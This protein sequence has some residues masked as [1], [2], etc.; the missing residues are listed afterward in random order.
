MVLS[1]HR[2]KISMAVVCLD[3][4]ILIWAMQKCASGER[5]NCIIIAESLIDDLTKNNDRIIIPSIV[6]AEL[7]A[8]I[9]D[10]RSKEF[11]DLI[12]SRFYIVPFDALAAYYYAVIFRRN[13]VANKN[14]LQQINPGRVNRS[15]DI[16]VLATAIAHKASV[17]YSED[18]HIH[19]LSA[20]SSEFVSV[21]RMPIPL[22]KQISLPDSET[23]I[24]Q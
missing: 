18:Q 8:G 3:T 21:R 22:P 23:S 19:A 11:M 13:K 6:Y 12:S 2:E 1:L 20:V 10:E 24:K 17:I 16:K 14:G 9:P 4:Q 7:L 5:K 15:A